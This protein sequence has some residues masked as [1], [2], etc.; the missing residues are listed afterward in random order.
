MRIAAKQLNSRCDG[1]QGMLF[2]KT[3]TVQTQTAT[4]ES[5]PRKPYREVLDE[6]RFATM[7]SDERLI[8]LC[9]AVHY[10]CDAQIQGDIVEC[11]VWK[12]GSMMA[13][14]HCLL[15]RN[16]ADR[17][18]W[19]YDTFCGMSEPTDQD[20]DFLGNHAATLMQQSDPQ[21]SDSVWCT[22]E[23]EEVKTNVKITGYPES[24]MNFIVGPVE[25][26]LEQG[27]LP[28]KIALLRLDT[29]WYEST[30]IELEQLFPR[31]SDGGVLIVDDYGHWEGCRKAVD[32]YFSDNET[33]MLLYRIDYTGRMGVKTSLENVGSMNVV[34]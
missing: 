22:A 8:A 20:V 21:Q 29:D 27:P 3:K 23:L 4:A 19:L 25:E 31:L 16:S 24:M 14:A 28:D 18:L 12:G 10:I 5:E 17:R 15:Q 26:T 7:T 33:K 34:A 9:D 6:V 13:A 1:S 2:R 32:E 30:K 11:G